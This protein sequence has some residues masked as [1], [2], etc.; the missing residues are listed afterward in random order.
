MAKGERI[1]NNGVPELVSIITIN[2]NQAEITRQFL[3]S[4]TRLTYPN[5][6]I[7]IVDNAST[8]T[9]SSSIDLSLYPKVR[10]IRS[11]TNLG[12]TGGNNL[13]MSEAKGDYFFI[14]NNDTEVSATLL[15]ELL[16]PFATDDTIG[17]TCPK[18]KFHASPKVLQFAGYNPMNMLTGTATAIGYNQPDE[19][20][21]DQ[22]HQTYFAHGCAMMIRRSVVKQVGRF[23]E[24]FFLYYE[25]LDWSQRIR[26]AGYQIYY[27]P[28]A[29]I[30]HKESASVGQQSTLKTYYLTRNRILFM[31]RHCS[32]FQRLVFYLYFTTCVFPKHII[33]YLVKGKIQHA[34]AFIDGTLWNL[35]STSVSPV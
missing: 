24:R 11:E 32:P 2:Y 3:E 27:Q 5:Y 28:T 6:E 13:G 31:R 23:A 21:Y 20:Q 9:L 17:V 12:F 14:V 19:G 10:L 16:K 1:G 35:R 15:D 8:E 7:I 22:P 26:N 30:L 33:S 29:T 25:E 18:I 34:R 4:T